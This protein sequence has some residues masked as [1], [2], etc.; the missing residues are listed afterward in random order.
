V[1]AQDRQDLKIEKGGLEAHLTI[2]PMSKE[3]GGH[4]VPSLAEL[5]VWLREKGIKADLDRPAILAALDK[6]S[7]GLTAD[8]VAARGKP[9]RPG[10][11]G[12]VEYLIDFTQSNTPTVTDAGVI[13]L[14]ASL[15]RNVKPGD[16]LAVIHAPTGGELGLDVH[17]K[18]I[19][20]VVG[21]SLDPRLGANTER[22]AN[23]AMLIV[24]A[25][26]GHARLIDGVLE[27]QEFYLVQSDV[28]YGSGNIS[29]GKSVLIQG[30]VKAGFSVDSGG[31]LEVTGLVED[32]LIKSQGKVFIK[33]GFTGQGKGLVHARGDVTLGYVRNQH[34]KGEKTLIVLKEAINSRLQACQSVTVNGLLAGGKVQARYVIECQVAGTETGTPTQLE[35]GFDFTVTE[36]MAEIRLEMEKMG[37]YSKKL[38]DSLRQIHDMEKLNR[39]LD[40]WTID[41][42]FEMEGARSKVEAKTQSLRE[43]FT[44][45]ENQSYD[46]DAAT[47]TVHRKVFPGVVI[48]IGREIFLVDEPMTGPKTFFAK[49]GVI[50][51][52]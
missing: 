32:C 5:E 51:V 24:A 4:L 8:V 44:L 48:K 43:R 30:D 33:G 35:V 9:P 36:E 31:D 50:Q 39:A 29:F 18:L 19:P 41:L 3:T 1:P 11:D 49:N 10:E 34:V 42:M 13:D 47:V 15:I 20:S 7:E 26:G 16:P 38:G 2:V 22:S 25:T 21:M 52:R 45:L 27:V 17:G 12:Y 28:D 23:D 37:S 14:R 40:P 46:P 6:A